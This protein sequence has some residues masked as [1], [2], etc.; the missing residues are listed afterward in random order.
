MEPFE[1]EKGIGNI[2]DGRNPTP[3]DMVNIPLFT[4]CYTSQVVVWDFFHQQYHMLEKCHLPYFGQGV[5]V[6]IDV[7]SDGFPPTR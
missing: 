2:V 4:G 1:L 5:I 6:I 3:V 7:T